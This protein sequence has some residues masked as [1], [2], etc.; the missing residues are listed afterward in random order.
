MAGIPEPF[1]RSHR[2]GHRCLVFTNF[3]AT[4]ELLSRK[5]DQ[6]GVEQQ[7][8]DRTHRIGQTRNIFSYR[9]I[10][11]GTIEEKMLELQEQKKELFDA[12]ISSEGQLMKRLTEEDI[13]YLL[14]GGTD[15]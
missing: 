9:I 1:D 6:L 15:A 4:V 12:L 2:G 5:L 14:A 7:A 10:A 3:L 13:D 11:R 8:I